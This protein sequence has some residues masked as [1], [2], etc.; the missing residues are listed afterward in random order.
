MSAITM[1][2]LSPDELARMFDDAIERAVMKAAVTD[3]RECGM[4][5]A[6]T[7]LDCSERTVARMEAAG[8]IP[9]RVDG[10]WLRADLLKHRRDRRKS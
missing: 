6:A 4:R 2:P 10:K 8:S 1:I 5:E 9:R 3:G 7:I